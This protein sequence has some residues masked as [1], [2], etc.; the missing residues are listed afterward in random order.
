VRETE[1]GKRDR[2][3]K[4]I[5]NKMRIK[6]INEDKWMPRQVEHQTVNRMH[7][8]FTGVS[9]VFRSPISDT[10]R[11]VLYEVGLKYYLCASFGSH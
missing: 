2:K 5:K 4:K 7:P 9:A 6:E 10:L 8:A 1:N 3:S 11:Q